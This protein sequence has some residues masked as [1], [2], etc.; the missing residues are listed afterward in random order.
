MQNARCVSGVAV[1]GPLQQVGP[2]GRPLQD[3][4]V[5]AGKEDSQRTKVSHPVVRL[6]S[7][8]A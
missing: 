8:S 1:A 6:T 5:T 7:G 3:S 2:S 4:A